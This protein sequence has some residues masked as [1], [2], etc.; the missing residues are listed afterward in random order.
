MSGTRTCL[1]LQLGLRVILEENVYAALCVYTTYSAKEETVDRVWSTGSSINDRAIYK[2]SM[3]STKL[4][5]DCVGAAI[6]SE[7]LGVD[8]APAWSQLVTFFRFPSR[9]VSGEWHVAKAGTVS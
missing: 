3:G 9:K 6:A 1:I 4:F 7:M 5:F 2:L 8:E